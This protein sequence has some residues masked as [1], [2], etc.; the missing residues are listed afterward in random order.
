[1]GGVV[2]LP[3][4]QDASLGFCLWR[5]GRQDRPVCPEINKPSDELI[6]DLEDAAAEILR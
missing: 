5:Y 2:S 1:M 4:R 3:I 6:F